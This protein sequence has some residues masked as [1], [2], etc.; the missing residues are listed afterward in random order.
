MDYVDEPIPFII[1]A[2]A[3]ETTPAAF[4]ISEQAIRFFESLNE[5]KVW[6]IR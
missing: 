2:P 4:S 1:C 3:S 5:K 6:M